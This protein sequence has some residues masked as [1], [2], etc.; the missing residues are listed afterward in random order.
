[1][2]GAETAAFLESG[3]VMIVATVGANGEPRATRGWGLTVLDAEGTRVRLVLD[4]DESVTVEH[5]GAHGRVAITGACVRT[6]RSTQLKGHAIELG[7]ATAADAERVE[8]YIDDMKTVIFEIDGT[9]R[10][11]LERMRPSRYVVC[12][13]AVE[14][15]YDQTPGPGAGAAIEVPGE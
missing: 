4:A 10:D 3:C 6:L 2:I 14:E 5:V 13:V 8:R 15:S 7:P 11:H 1:V 9:P 12:T